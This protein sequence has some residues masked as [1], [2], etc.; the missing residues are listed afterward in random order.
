M[1]KKIAIIVRDRKDEALRMA[2]GATLSNDKV[3][4]FIMDE[5]LETDYDT[6]VNLQMLS[7]LNARIFSNNPDNPFEQRTTAE[8]AKM[9]TGYDVVIPY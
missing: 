2:V 8:I 4:V 6:S 9:L 5:K 3:D 7:D 1:I